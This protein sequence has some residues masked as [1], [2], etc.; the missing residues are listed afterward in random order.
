MHFYSTGQWVL[1]FFLYCFC[2][3]VWESCYVSACKRHWVNRGFLQGPIL[4]IYGSGAILI[5]FVTLPVE[6]NLLLV[7][8]FGMIAATILEYITGAVM[9]R[10]FKV[11]YWDYSNHMVQ[12]NG[13]I[14]LSSSIAWGFF[15]VL[16]IRYIHPPV[17]RL[18]EDVPGWIVDP[19]ALIMVVIFTVDVVQSTQAALD[20]KEVL[21]RLTEENED[22]RRLARRAEII[23][24]FREDDLK[25]FRNRTEL[26]KLLLEIRLGEDLNALHEA[27]IQRKMKRKE[28]LEKIFQKRVSVKLHM[29]DEILDVLEEHMDDVPN[30]STDSKDIREIIEKVHEYKH[31]IKERKIKRYRKFMRILHANPS[32]KAKGFEDVMEDLRDIDQDHK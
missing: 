1:L 9:E 10:I 2:G 11:R 27:R 15:S 30:E 13:Y 20:F 17:G 32:A 21:E 8:I 12:L 19:L 5:L 31:R 25:Q 24:A 26:D 23:A 18:I 6:Q 22:L 3:W 4:P 29:L 16:L 14:C 28:R 7:F